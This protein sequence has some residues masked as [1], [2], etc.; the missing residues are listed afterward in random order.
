MTITQEKM[1]F[2]LR[3]SKKLNRKLELELESRNKFFFF[4]K[5][6]L[7]IEILNGHFRK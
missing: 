6:S 4:S 7:I 3:L 5:N 2:V 1:N